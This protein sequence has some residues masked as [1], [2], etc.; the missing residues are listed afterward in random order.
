MNG[1][2]NQGQPTTQNFQH[3]RLLSPI[4]N[5]DSHQIS[6]ANRPSR[7]RPSRGKRPRQLVAMNILLAAVAIIANFSGGIVTNFSP[8]NDGHWQFGGVQQI[9]TPVRIFPLEDLPL[10]PDFSKNDRQAFQKNPHQLP[11]PPPLIWTSEPFAF[12]GHWPLPVAR[13]L[14]FPIQVNR[15]DAEDFA[16]IQG[17]GPALA[18][19]IIQ[20]KVIRG[21]N[22]T[23]ETMSSIRGI[24]PSK[25]RILREA[26]GPKADVLPLKTT[27][28]PFLR[29]PKSNDLR[30]RRTENLD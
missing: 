29:I 18:K 12:N 22:L 3:H 27:E 23:P 4:Q 24:G 11:N 21:G 30:M 5:N 2:T 13:L 26:L 14:D 28:E 25:I 10:T 20:T 1:Q 15:L 6:Q 9:Q 17:I 8:S 16:T 19:R 7:N